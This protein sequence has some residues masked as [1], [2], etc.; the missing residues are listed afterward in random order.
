MMPAAVK[1]AEEIFSLAAG[2]TELAHG[3]CRTQAPEVRNR[4]DA[5]GR[6]QEQLSV[7]AD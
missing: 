6:V 7:T 4:R 2:L 1:H 3:I 5:F